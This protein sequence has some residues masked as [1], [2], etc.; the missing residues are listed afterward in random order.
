M[1]KPTILLTLLGLLWA[2]GAAAQ[3][4][5]GPAALEVRADG[6]RGK[7]IA[8]AEVKLTYLALE[9]PDGP[10][11]VKVDS[12]GRA[13]VGGLAEGLWRV[14]VSQ[15][16]YMTFQAEVEV[17]Q[18]GK[19]DVVSTLQL[20]VPNAV[21]MMD[22]RFAKARSAPAAMAPTPAASAPARPAPAAPAPSRPVAEAPSSPTPTPVAPPAQPAPVR[23]EPTPAPSPAAEPVP[24]RPEPTSAPPSTPAPQSSAPRAEAPPIPPARAPEP[25]PPVPAPV[26]R[27]E[28][29]VPA[30]TPAP[31]PEPPAPTVRRRSAQDRTCFECKPGESALSVEEVVP[32]GE[33][34]GGCGQG[35]QDLLRNADGAAG[36]PAGCRMLRIDLPAG[37]RYTGYRYEVQEGEQTLDC[38]AGREC[39]AGAGRWPIDPVL[40][41]SAAGTTITAAFEAR[42]SSRERRAV[43]TVY[44]STATTRRSR[45]TGN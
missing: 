37:L 32:A 14:E 40:A 25:A 24:A 12:K 2:S 11:P 3:L 8:G 38:L 45:G 34:A 27:V 33:A 16:G 23:P 44:Y 5:R 26:P 20:N 42:G 41:R 15:E 13:V 29:L 28:P 43:L 31:T 21:H 1:R 30:P 35:I 7:S 39:T 10:A 22:V 9:P 6:Q 19:P 36:L 4:W 17:R 18:D